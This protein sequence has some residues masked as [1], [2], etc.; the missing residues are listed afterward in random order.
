MLVNTWLDNKAALTVY[1][2]VSA[3]GSVKED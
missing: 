3:T 1:T 2:N